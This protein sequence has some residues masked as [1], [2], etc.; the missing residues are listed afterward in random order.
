MASTDF[1]KVASSG[2][3]ANLTPWPFRPLP[4]AFAGMPTVLCSGAYRFFFNAPDSGE[5]PQV[6]VDRDDKIGS[7]P[8]DP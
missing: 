3:V 2:V 1:G 8:G 4:L 6:H 7:S 5:P